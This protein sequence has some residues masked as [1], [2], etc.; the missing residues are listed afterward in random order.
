M[1]CESGRE[2]EAQPGGT[3]L[4]EQKAAWVEGFRPAWSGRECPLDSG[5]CTAGGQA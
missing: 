3:E 1:P 5:M 4:S 2:P